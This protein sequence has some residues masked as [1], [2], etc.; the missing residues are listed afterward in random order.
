MEDNTMKIKKMIDDD[1]WDKLLNEIKNG[2]ITNIDTYIVNGNNL[3]HIACIKG[4]IEFIKKLFDLRNKKSLTFNPNLINQDG[5]T[6]SHLYYKYGGNDIFFMTNKELCYLDANNFSLGKYLIDRIDL[7]EHLINNMQKIG[8]LENIDIR[9]DYY[10]YKELIEKIK[11]YQL[12]NPEL[13]NRYL[14]L[15]EKIYVEI[16][17]KDLV[18]LSIIWNCLPIIDMLILHNYDF[19]IYSKKNY[20]VLSMCTFYDRVEMIIHIFEYTKINMGIET[21]FK[22]IHSSEINYDFRP[23]FLAID[24]NNYHIIEM[25]M[26]YMN[27]YIK[28]KTYYMDETDSTLNTYLHALLTVKD[29]SVIPRKIMEFFI[30][31]TDLNKENY[32]GITSAHL[33]FGKNIWHDYK[34]ILKGREIDLL[35]LDDLENNCYS[36]IKPEDKKEF[37]EFTKHIKIPIK[38]KN[39]KEINKLFDVQ[40]V[41][42]I[43]KLS[44][45]QSKEDII[46][47]NKIGKASIEDVKYKNYGLF[48]SNLPHYML[49]LK[50]LMNKYKN[51]YVPYQIYNEENFTNDVF[52]YNLIS[53]YITSNE[54]YVLVKNIKLYTNLYYSFLPHNIYWLDDDCYFIHPKLNEILKNHNKTIDVTVNR[55]IMI[56]ISIII[57]ENVLHANVLLYDRL[58]KEAWRFEP[59][60]TTQVTYKAS[61][62]HKMKELLEEVYGKITYNNPSDYLSGLNFQMVDGEDYTITKNLGDPGGY[63]LAWTLWFVDIVL[64]HQDKN[65][66]YI[67]KNFFNRKDISKIL[68][69]EIGEDINSTNYYLDFIRRYAQKLDEEKNHI[70]NNIGIKKYYV[71]NTVFRDDVS[72]KIEEMFKM[73]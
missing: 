36:Y 24:T 64:S 31:H 3:F 33:I 39:K 38:I 35:K 32:A 72:E 49:Y 30:N 55:Y 51:I 6:G 48:N 47:E 8:C 73:R 17:P 37:L 15:V 69:E 67:M 56:K 71:Y 53:S 60:G 4:K 5:L 19:N 22:M 42:Q 27:I 16:K 57:S 23:I 43:L 12:S 10:M 40:N 59:Y 29:I 9:L 68:S 18:F 41:K 52:L 11:E 44:S 70:L 45:E 14:K 13:S 50:Y 2:N 26:E 66:K 21:V 20:T 7:L 65:V 54:Q 1:N 46:D 34:D 62:D 58:N 61:M 25:F 63:C 28:D